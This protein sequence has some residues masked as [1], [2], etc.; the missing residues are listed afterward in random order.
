MEIAASFLKI[1]NDIE[2]IKELNSLVG[3]IHYD[4]MD[5][6]FVK[7]KTI[8][9]NEMKEI[10]QIITC[11]KDIHLMVNDVYKYVDIYIKLNPDYIIF[12]YETNKDIEEKINYIKNQNIKVGIAINPN[13]N[14]ILL[15]PYLDKIDLV[16]IMSVPPGKGGQEFIDISY[17]VDYFYE[18][19]KENNL[20]YLIEVDGGINDETIKLINKADIAVV[21]SFITDS[22]DYKK[23]INKIEGAL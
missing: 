21:G 13:T 6:I 23:Q 19:R 5:G 9:F 22:N 15:R 16:L 1:Q 8:G 2:K 7:N 20:N 10:N 17:K 3:R 11:T 14:P 12:H 18:I 4:I